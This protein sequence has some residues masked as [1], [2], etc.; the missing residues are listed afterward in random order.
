MSA[1]DIIICTV[2]ISICVSIVIGA[3]YYFKQEKKQEEE[4]GVL[5]A[6]IHLLEERLFEVEERY[7]E[8]MAKY[9]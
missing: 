4:V 2:V 7:V 3:V 1:L 5:K 9:H 8:H 6:K